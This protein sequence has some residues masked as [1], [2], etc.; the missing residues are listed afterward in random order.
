MLKDKLVIDKDYK[1]IVK[2]A[3][4]DGKCLYYGT[5]EEEY[6]KQGYLIVTEEEFEPIHEKYLNDMCNNWKEISEDQFENALDVLP[7]LRWRNGG[8]Y[9]SEMYTSDVT[10]FYQQLGDKFYTSYQ[11]LSYNRDDILSNLRQFINNMN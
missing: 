3:I 11:R 2:T 4:R 7:P 9:I 5:P 6:I 8:F 1:G 10:N